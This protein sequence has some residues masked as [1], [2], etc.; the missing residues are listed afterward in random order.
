MRALWTK[1]LTLDQNNEN[2]FNIIALEVFRYQNQHVPI[3]RD[4][5]DLIGV[6]TQSITHYSEIPFLPISFFKSHKIQTSNGIAPPP[7]LVFE[8]SGTSGMEVS[9]HY[10]TDPEIYLQSF[11]YTFRLFYGNPENYVFLCLLPSYLERSNSSLVYMCR[12]LVE[13]SRDR[14]SGFY[15]YNME[16]L[17]DFVLRYRGDKKL[18]I[19]GVTFAL[20]DFADQ[21]SEDLSHCIL[22]ETGGMKGRREEWTR[23]QV[24]GFLK[25]KLCL[26]NIHSE[27][28]MTEL[29]SQAY[30]KAN[31]I[32]HTPPFMKVLPRD[33]NDPMFTLSSGT[34]LLN[35]IDLAN[36]YSCSFIATDDIGKVYRDHSFEVSG[37]RDNSVLRGCSL[38]AL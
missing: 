1:C 7:D 8:S 22:M 18:F 24:H 28:G 9:R 23:E 6:D 13:L 26:E 15:L 3:Y 20:L 14:D 12:H 35:I 17:R 25:R 4:F 27:Y 11:T 5:I 10:I 34:G 29:L 37:R 2:A 36:L 19:I 31:G 16:A 30:S 33:I 21:F 32:F 38:M